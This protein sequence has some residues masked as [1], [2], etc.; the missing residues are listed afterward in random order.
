MGTCMNDNLY[1]INAVLRFH[2]DLNFSHV[3][4]EQ[5][6]SEFFLTVLRRWPALGRT[7]ARQYA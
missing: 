7:T 3:T 2:F 5:L 6:L 1:L 4:S